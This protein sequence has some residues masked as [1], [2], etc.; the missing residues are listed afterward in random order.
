MP[1]YKSNVSDKQQSD[2]ESAENDSAMPLAWWNHDGDGEFIRIPAY[3]TQPK[4]NQ[5][6]QPNDASLANNR[7]QMSIGSHNDNPHRFD[8]P[9]KA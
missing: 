3:D 2:I 5:S 9:G 7:K 6:G 4:H 1:T 8:S